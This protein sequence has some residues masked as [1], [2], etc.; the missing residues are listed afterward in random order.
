M[1]D[2][3]LKHPTPLF[4]TCEKPLPVHLAER[5]G[6]ARSVCARCERPLRLRL[7]RV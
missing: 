5:K 7:R 6:A 4:C 1:A 2:H 3:A